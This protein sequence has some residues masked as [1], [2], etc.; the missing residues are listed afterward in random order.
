MSTNYKNFDLNDPTTPAPWGTREQQA[1]EDIIDTIV[2][3]S[4]TGLAD[5]SVGHKHTKFY[6][7]SGN[8]IFSTDSSNNITIA[9]S[10]AN[11]LIMAG[12]GANVLTLQADSMQFT[13]GGSH[14]SD[15]VDIY[16]SAGTSV[17][18]AL[19]IL[20]SGG[21]GT[22]RTASGDMTIF[23]CGGTTHIQ[24]TEG[25]D[26]GDGSH[27]AGL[28]F[29]FDSAGLIPNSSAGTVLGGLF[30]SGSDNVLRIRLA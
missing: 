1:L 2:L 13:N 30:H 5:P 19:Q 25:I 23:G 22:F 10:V 8:V 12:Q 20:P 16:I 11:M 17:P 21:G 14:A 7:N 24:G 29:N 15:P 26:F 3:D 9:S 28:F 18:K 6:D 27:S 4:L